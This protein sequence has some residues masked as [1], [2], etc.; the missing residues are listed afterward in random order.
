MNAIYKK[1]NCSFFSYII[2][3]ALFVCALLCKE[4]ITSYISAICFGFYI[5]HSIIINRNR[6]FLK[7]INIL[8]I[9]VEFLIGVFVCDN[10]TTWLGEINATTF[11]CGAFSLLTFYYW[12]LFTLLSFIDPFYAK[13]TKRCKVTVNYLPHRNSISDTIY[14]Y[15]PNI[16]FISGVILFVSVAK[17]P[18]FLMHTENRFE[19][20]QLYISRFVN[21]FRIFPTL[22]ISLYASMIL[23]KRIVINKTNIV[24]ILVSLSPYILFLIWSGNKF[25]AFSELFLVFVIPIFAFV[26]LKKE[27]L[28]KI[29][30][31]LLCVILF[32]VFFLF[33]Y[34]TLNGDSL[35]DAYEKIKIRIACQGELWWKMIALTDDG[36]SRIEEVGQEINNILMSI[37]TEGQSKDYGVYHLMK[38]LGNPGTIQSYSTINTRFTSSGIELPFYY[39]R[40][41][42][43]IIMPLLICP[44][45]AWINNLY[46][47]AVKEERCLAS[48]GSARILLIV[49]GAITQGDWYVFFSLIPMCCFLGVF[50]SQVLSKKIMFNNSRSNSII[51]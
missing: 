35:V 38:L 21:I 4:R 14:N 13:C 31:A 8:I 33:L 20:S 7:Y 30:K 36:Y 15:T 50:I 39:F 6:F 45:I 43:F 16:V 47:N 26:E 49:S 11:Y 41:V 37:K 42:A 40:Y 17:N 27:V 9:A 25:G 51:N 48:I 19:Y 32:L 24:K 18:S 28:G 10:T 44:L 29:I 46:I 34:Y 22:F 2:G 12:I 5:W 1:E 23:N 3:I